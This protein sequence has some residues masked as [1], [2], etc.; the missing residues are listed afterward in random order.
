MV[1]RAGDP[2]A[3]WGSFIAAIRAGKPEMANGTALQAHYGCVLGHL[4]NNSYRLGE[5]VP[6]NAKA[7][8]FGDQKDAAEHFAKLHEVMK[9]GVGI[10]ENDAQ[11]TVG[12]WL[13]F[14]PKTERHVGDHAE[15]ANALLKDENSAGFQIPLDGV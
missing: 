14:D 7:G 12:P 8:K 3:N 6:F 5:Q 10:P 2:A 1:P 9:D 11:Y 13:T 15:K 4:M